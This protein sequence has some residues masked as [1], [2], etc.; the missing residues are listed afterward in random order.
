MKRCA[1]CYLPPESESWSARDRLLKRGCIESSWLCIDCREDP[2][3]AMWTMD[4]EQERSSDDV[5]GFPAS[6]SWDQVMDAPLREATPLQREILRMAVVDP[7]KERR[8][9]VY[10]DKQGRKRGKR[11]RWQHV[12]SARGIAR[13]VGCSAQYVVM[14]LR[15]YMP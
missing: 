11:E 2:A 4:R 12:N 5:D 1:V 6:Q 15:R 9:V 13:K 3:N 8:A 7:G 10:R 14:T